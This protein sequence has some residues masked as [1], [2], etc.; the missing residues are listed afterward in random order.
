MNASEQNKQNQQERVIPKLR[1]PEF[2]TALGWKQDIL[3][4]LFDERGKKNHPE[5][6]ILAAT[7]DKG[8]I[9]YELM[10]K[11]VIRDRKNLN[12]Y[13]LVL[14]EDFVISLRSFEGGFEY[15][16]YE[17]IISPAYVILYPKIKICNY[18]FRIY[19]KRDSFIQQIQNNLN[20]SLRDGKSISYKQAA[21]LKIALPLFEEQQKI[22]DCLSSLDELIELQEQ[23]LAA[24]KQHKKGLMQQLFPNHNDL[25]ASK[26]ASKIVYPKLRFPQFKN[27]EGWDVVELRD[28]G[29]F[30]KEKMEVI[31]L[32]PPNYISTENLLSDYGGVTASNKLPATEKVTAYKK[33]DILVS[34]IRPYLKK[35]WQADKNGG[36]SNDIIIIR[37][38][39]SINI[40]FLSFA[41]KNDDFIDYMMKGA[42][43]V[44]MPRGDLNL[45]SIFPVAVPTSPKEQ[46]AIAD[47][48][49]SLDNLINEQN[50]R[51]GRLK[52]HK[53]GL[54][55][56]LFPNI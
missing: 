14:P 56:Q 52:T 19:F 37:A 30:V 18:F 27:C 8:V 21:G 53:K 15:S 41:I 49:S 54:M 31:N 16:A 55:Q 51:I 25:Q 38:K 28:V 20:N 24:L 44:K 22:A 47:C 46:Q 40:S 26:Q 12:G 3:G 13:K 34:N 42:K 35:V 1:F 39:P 2:Q 11:S 17:G 48:L 23:K 43:G 33:N 10:E 32:E 45:I 7:Q 36:A 29:Y 6:T 4:N 5:K 9:P 50:E